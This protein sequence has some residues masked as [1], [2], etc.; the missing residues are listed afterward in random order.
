MLVNLAIDHPSDQTEVSSAI[1]LLFVNVHE[2]PTV[3][4]VRER[5]RCLSTSGRS[6]LAGGHEHQR[7]G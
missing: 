2:M 6:P 4:F 1:D 7:G 3:P 5:A